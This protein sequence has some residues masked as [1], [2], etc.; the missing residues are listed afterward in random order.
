MKQK[1]LLSF[2]AI[3]FG[4]L[5]VSAQ[6]EEKLIVNAGNAERIT[7]A[8]DMDVVLLPGTDAGQSI[9]LNPE[10]AK[11]LKLNLSANSM[12]ISPLKQISG[13][14]RLKVFLYV[15][16]LKTITVENNSHVKTIGVLDSPKLEV[17]IDGEATVHLK[18][19]GDIKA[20]SLSDAEINITYISD[21]RVAKH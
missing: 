3:T 7:I 10:A 8:N 16:A 12:T 21:T 2:M 9:S 15:N 11:S 19:N 4:V 18:T 5:S 1:F 6:A 13:K 17:Y 14:E 20:Q